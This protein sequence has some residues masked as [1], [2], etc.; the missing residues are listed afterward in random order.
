MGV[1]PDRSDRQLAFAE[2]NQLGFPLLADTD[3]SVANQFGV[4]RFGPLPI[5]RVT[6]V[7]GTDRRVAAVIKS[8]TNMNAHADQAL[9]EVRKLVA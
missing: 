7:I 3:K 4:T 8:E 6:F 1:S 2:A 9:D 5:K